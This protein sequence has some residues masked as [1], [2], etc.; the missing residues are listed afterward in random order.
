MIEIEYILKLII[1]FYNLKKDSIWLVIYR[2][3]GKRYMYVL[4]LNLVDLSI[5][6]Y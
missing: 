3:I 6:L 1:C 4:Y 2:K 5:F